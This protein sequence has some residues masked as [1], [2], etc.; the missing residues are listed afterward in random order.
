M[1]RIFAF[2]D[3]L[4][5]GYI[6]KNTVRFYPYTTMLKKRLST[7][8]QRSVV[9][10]NKGV[11]GE[12]TGSM[13]ERIRT[14]SPPYDLSILLAGTNDLDDPRM[15]VASIV[16]NII[17]LHTYCL[18]ELGVSHTLCLSIPEVFDT[19]K[20]GAQKEGTQHPLS[21]L[22]YESK[23]TKINLK[24]REFCNRKENSRVHYVPFGEVF[25]QRRAT[26]N[27]FAGN[28][29]HLSVQ[30]YRQ[31]GEFLAEYIRKH[32]LLSVSRRK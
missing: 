22:M 14:Y 31:M 1:T 19:S 8:E 18:D 7:L 9:V 17:R 28:G 4:T 15:S 27:V 16:R 21:T 32:K 20:K 10:H 23:R 11:S 5:E 29:Y 30:G 13:V 26:P 3:S 6:T 2:G 12:K 25:S 24:L